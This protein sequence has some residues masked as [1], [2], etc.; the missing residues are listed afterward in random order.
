MLTEYLIPCLLAIKIFL[1]ALNKRKTLAAFSGTN[2]GGTRVTVFVGC[3]SLFVLPGIFVSLAS[4]QGLSRNGDV[5]SIRGDRLEI[6]MI[7]PY[8]VKAGTEGYIFTTNTVNGRI[9]EVKAATIRVLEIKGSEGQETVICRLLERFRPITSDYWFGAKF[10]ETTEDLRSGTVYVLSTPNGASVLVD[11]ERKGMTPILFDL[12]SGSRTIQVTLSGHATETRTVSVLGGQTVKVNLY[13]NRIRR[14]EEGRSG[15][16]YFQ[17]GLVLLEIGDYNLAQRYLELAVAK[18]PEN[19]EAQD[20]LKKAQALTGRTPVVRS[21]PLAAVKAPT[22]LKQKAEPP[23]L[24]VPPAT[25]PTPAPKPEVAPAVVA[26]KT[27]V[28]KRVTSSGWTGKPPDG[29]ESWRKSARRFIEKNDL[30]GAEIYVRNILD[31]N[32]KDI[33]AQ[34]WMV[35]IIG[36]VPTI[37]HKDEQ[38]LILQLPDGSEMKL[39]YVV[40]GTFDMGDTGGDGEGDEKPVHPVTVSKLWMG[41]HEITNLQYATF[42]NAWGN[43][44]EEGATWL[45]LKDDD[46]EIALKEGKFIAKEGTEKLPVVE[47]TWHG[48]M[49]FA[50][51]AGGRLP[52]EAEWE[53]AAR[54][55]GKK[56]KYPSGDAL[57]SN[58]ANLTGKNGMDQWEPASPIGSFQPNPLGL[59]DLAGNVWEWCLDWYGRD[60]YSNSRGTNPDGPPK[61]DARVLRGGSWY[62]ATK[63]A[64]T[65]YRNMNRPTESRVNIGFRIVVPGN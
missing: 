6:S 29:L 4:A 25:A 52:T 63:L 57:T 27:T 15:V 64:R 47:V 22:I 51:W 59:F 53:Y 19:T 18:M 20:W 8:K 65:S 55:T 38:S 40:G 30:R 60:Y 16:F 21:E 46:C 28:A 10:P 50:R 9:T 42:L 43:Q 13:L 44:L 48:A 31:W 3:L 23:S 7:A 36:P 58:E 34:E 49:A 32:P 54:N 61:G 12:P 24:P 17:K 37:T 33:E 35:R 1:C 56:V 62:D 39:A 26:E 45:D 5:L 14:I 41:I 2:N 11:G